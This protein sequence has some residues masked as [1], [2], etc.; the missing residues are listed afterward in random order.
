MAGHAFDSSGD[1]RL[2]SFQRLTQL[3]F[4]HSSHSRV[5]VRRDHTL[6]E[7]HRNPAVD[8]EE[9]VALLK[10]VGEIAKQ[11]QAVGQ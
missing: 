2:R 9:I 6:A 8:G 11:R 4:R 5:I 10:S 1:I 3:V 7:H